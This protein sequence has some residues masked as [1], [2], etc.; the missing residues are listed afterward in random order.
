MTS[1]HSLTW[2]CTKPNNKLVNAQLEHFWCQDEPQANSDSQDS[3]RPGLGGNHHLP[4]YNILCAQPQQQHPNVILSCD[5]QIPIV[6]TPVILGTHNFACKPPIEMRFKAKLQPSLRDF[7]WYVAC[8]DMQG[9]RCDSQ[10]LVVGSQIANLTPG[11]SF[12][13]NLCVKCPN[14]SC[15]PILDIKVLRAFQ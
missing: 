6:G 8:H 3:P 14:G 4:P 11:P 2:S 1:N 7:Q 12:D 15:E 9:N 5:S 13:Y 10:L